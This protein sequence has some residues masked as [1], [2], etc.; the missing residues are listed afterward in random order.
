M[1]AIPQRAHSNY[2]RIQLPRVEPQRADMGRVSDMEAYRMQKIAAERRRLA[3]QDQK[4]NTARRIG[5]TR[6]SSAAATQQRRPV[7]YDTVQQRPAARRDAPR[8]VQGERYQIRQ[9]GVQ[10]V[11]G[12]RKLAPAYDGYASSFDNNERG[13]T[14]R[15]ARMEYARPRP[16]V[17]YGGYAPAVK[18]NPRDYERT[19]EIENTSYDGIKPIAVEYEGSKKK[20]VVSTILLIAFVFAILCG[21]VI[22]YASISD[23]SYK[24]AQIQTENAVLA[25]ELDKVKMDNA[26]KEDLNGIQQKASSELGMYY[27]KDEQIQYLESDAAETEAEASTEIVQ[28][29]EPDV[30]QNQNE[31]ID[32]TNFLDGVKNF[33][34]GIMEVVGGWF[35]R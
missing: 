6:R 35:Q 25:D 32:S 23:I 8:E 18:R 30:T 34:A 28:Q 20:G 16:A 9:S 13:N 10:N 3:Q 4:S 19:S 17:N 29:K 11:V 15:Y 27:P 22:R 1:N 24:N 2:E 33:F 14:A 21:I 26:L 12:G 5:E 7:T 31:K